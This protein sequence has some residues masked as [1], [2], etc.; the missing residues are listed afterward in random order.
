MSQKAGITIG[1]L[2]IVISLA[3]QQGLAQMP[4]EINE[5]KLR[6]LLPEQLKR[7]VEAPLPKTSQVEWTLS[8]FDEDNEGLVER[9]V[10]RTAGETIWQSNLGNERREHRAGRGASAASEA[11]R[12]DS[13]VPMSRPKGTQNKMIGEGRQWYIYNA[14]R[15]FFGETST[16]EAAWGNSP[17]D[18]RS[19]GLSA[20]P[21]LDWNSFGLL[22]PSLNG[23]DLATFTTYQ[24]GT[25]DVVTADYEDKH[26]EWYL[27]RTKNGL[28]VHAAFYQ[29]A[30]LVSSSET[31]YSNIS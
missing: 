19:I 16:L 7:I 13:G 27:D 4:Y 11:A 2:L 23:F 8:W 6:S 5:W 26:L 3:G 14:D 21:H 9:C 30:K 22:P 10:T 15:G 31:D 28:P 17:V 24:Q 18:F 12:E 29:G 20:G 25:F 1:I